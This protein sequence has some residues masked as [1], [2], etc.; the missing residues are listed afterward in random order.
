MNKANLILERVSERLGA[1]AMGEL[2]SG[3]EY[4]AERD[5]FLAVG[6]SIKSIRRV[7]L[8]AHLT[9]LFED[10]VCT[11]LQVHEELRWCAGPVMRGA[12]ENV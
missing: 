2:I 5:H 6:R 12:Q 7:P 8:G 1:I 3:S 11:W 4:E 9:L 10:R